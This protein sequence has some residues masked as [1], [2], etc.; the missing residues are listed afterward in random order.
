MT[1]TLVNERIIKDPEKKK[2]PSEKNS[3]IH[4]EFF[5]VIPD[6]NT[7]KEWKIR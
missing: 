3:A 2:I 6:I 4:F 5:K 1:G 7:P